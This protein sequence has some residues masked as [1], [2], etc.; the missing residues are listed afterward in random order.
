MNRDKKNIDRLFEQGL[1]GYKESPPVYSWD[2]LD[3]GLGKA[4]RQKTFFYLRLLAASIIILFAFGAGYF[5]G[6]YNLN[7]GPSGQLSVNDNTELPV[8][9]PSTTEISDV[10]AGG[11]EEIFIKEQ[12]VPDIVS[13]NNAVSIA[14]VESV[15]YVSSEN[16]SVVENDNVVLLAENSSSR[17]IKDAEIRKLEMKE[18]TSIIVEKEV[19]SE[20]LANSYPKKNTKILTYYDI[21]TEPLQEYGFDDNIVKSN[22]IRW[23]VGAQVAPIYSYRDISTTYSSGSIANEMSYNNSEDPMTS[24]AAGVDVN[25][26]VSKRVSFQTGMYYSQI[27]QINNDALS[28]VEDDGKFLL[29]SI[30][31]SLGVIDFTMENVPLDIRE[32]VDAKDTVDLINQLNV[33]VVEGFDIFEVPLM[34]RYKVLNKKFSIN[35][36]G[37]VSPAFVTNNSAYLEVDAHKYDVENSANINSVFF[38]SS[39]S[40]GLEYSFLKKLSVNFEPTFKYALSPIN[41]DGDF[42]YHPYSISWFTGLKYSF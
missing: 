1:K 7:K 15:N 31:T 13:E 24:I 27:G 34:L 22:A 21:E 17:E 25:Y 36:M 19:L 6:V 5:Y 38:N 32:I 10:K 12:V 9:L 33:K 42:D 14:G 30:K 26:S 40:L 41:K 16:S 37:G 23:T 20:M 4:D 3:A 28:F 11:T 39:L 18:I 29:Y 8:I 2:R 35:V